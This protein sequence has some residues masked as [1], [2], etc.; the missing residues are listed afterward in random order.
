M[1]DDVVEV[2][3]ISSGGAA[4]VRNMTNGYPVQN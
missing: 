1:R 4:L 2:I 3:N